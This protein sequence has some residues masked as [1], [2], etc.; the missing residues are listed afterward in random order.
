MKMIADMRKVY[1][2]PYCEMIEIE[3]EQKMLTVST[4]ETTVELY[5][6]TT[7]EQI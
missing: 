1:S 3:L 4:E 5:E 6:A 2:E 7:E